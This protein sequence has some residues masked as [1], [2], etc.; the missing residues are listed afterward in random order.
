[1]LS[2]S[3][4]L[5]ALYTYIGASA[6]MLLYTAWWLARHWRAGWVALA[7]LLGAAV[8]LTPAYPKEGVST[9]APALIVAVFQFMTEGLEG[10]RH[11]LRP[12]AAACA[13][14]VVLAILLRFTV[15]RHSRFLDKRR[16]SR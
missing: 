8:L 13:L 7:V 11:A 3:S 4:Y 15:F 16:G 10:A 5:T 1:V 12:L 14:A 2:E 9:F 6:V